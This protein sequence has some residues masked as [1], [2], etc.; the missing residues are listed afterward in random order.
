MYETNVRWSSDS[1]VQMKAN[2]TVLASDFYIF[3][4]SQVINNKVK[5]L[6]K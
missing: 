5:M 1:G 3:I 2:V 4:S 6:N